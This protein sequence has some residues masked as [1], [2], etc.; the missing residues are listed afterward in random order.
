MWDTLIKQ[1]NHFIESGLNNSRFPWKQF[2]LSADK[3]QKNERSALK[4]HLDTK[5]L[6]RTLR[7]DNPKFARAILL[8]DPLQLVSEIKGWNLYDL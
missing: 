5:I 4:V 8:N 6:D 1:I 3:L 2:A 7:D